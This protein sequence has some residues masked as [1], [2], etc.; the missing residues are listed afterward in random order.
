MSVDGGGGHNR[1]GS[2]GRNGTHK[3]DDSNSYSNGI[4]VIDENKEFTP[5]LPAYL[6]AQNLITTGFSYHVVAVFGSQSTGKST[7]LNHLF[8]T[9]FSVM[10][11]QARRQT[12]K[13][14]WMSRAVEDAKRSDPR[15]MGNNI[16][17]MDVEGTDG[18]ERGEDQDFERKSALFALATSEVLIVNIWEHQVGLYQGANMGLLKT[19]FEVNLGL[20]LKDRSTTHRSLLFF[21]IRDHIGHT[22]LQNLSNTL[23]QDLNR[24]WSSLSKPPGLEDS[25]INDFFDFEFVALP[26][27]IL[28]PERFV[29]ETQKLRKRF[30]EGISPEVEVMSGSNGVD[31]RG[32]GGGVFLPVYHRRIPADGFPRYASGVWTQ[33][34][35]NKDLDLPS[36]Q[37]LLAQY[38]CDEIAATCTAGFNE[39]MSPFE[40][41][42]K[43][44]RVLEGLGGAMKEALGEA[45]GGFEESGG[46]YHKGVF[47]RKREDLRENLE[48]RL[49]GLVVG[50][51]SALSKRAVQEFTEEVTGI[52]RLANASGQSASSNYDFALV[53]NQ[54][55]TKVVDKFIAEASESYIPGAE[56]S[57][58][59]SELTSLQT[60]LD[61]IAAKLRGEQMQRLVARLEKA[62]RS[63]LAEPVELEFRRMEDNS[64]EK[65]NLWDRVWKVWTETVGEGVEGFL[66]RAGNLNATEKERDI[67]AWKLR[68]KAWGVLKAKIEEEVMEGNILLKLRENF[69]D[70]FRYDE[71]GVPR[72]WKPK[73]PIEQTYTTAREATLKL[74]P[75]I[76]R[77]RL[78]SGVEPPLTEFLSD[79]PT[80]FEEDVDEM[81][82][83]KDEFEV[84]G[85]AKQVDLST[86]FKR[87][88][89]AVFVEAKRSTVSSVAE[90]PVFF[91]GV[92]LALGWNELWAVLRSPVYFIFLLLCGAAAYVV[93]TLN[94]WGPILRITN[95][96]GQQ[97]VDIGKERLRDF[98]ADRNV[99][100]PGE[101]NRTKGVYESSDVINL[102]TLDGEGR[103][104]TR[105]KREDD[106][107]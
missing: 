87:M 92:M 15:G 63:K 21:V 61:E 12:T 20:F 42:A 24:I 60:A 11:E 51:F 45:M 102:Q 97:A 74:I 70:R 100:Y 72:V 82:I 67:G 29:E 28:Q 25:K 56:W 62:I 84:L 7:L 64:E 40:E 31:Q 5:Y 52:L 4:Q 85:E 26:H 66:T 44:G 34:V 65:G 90:I 80:D 9:Q 39:I 75:L 32:D 3:K 69:E 1:S 98:V 8:G 46:R 77:I 88:A 2:I 6:T 53:V 48:G 54:T 86:R 76:S 55:R 94:L 96:M 78:S 79:P 95:A 47:E 59:E 71:Q 50:Q 10:D 35:T 103:R 107:E 99:A 83:A 33:I 73:D 89:D 41:R 57:N 14:I 91:W 43:A 81:G 19:V 93:Y 106:D 30:R 101:V 16:L 104:R 22:P 36:Q 58:Y 105:I 49:R 23:M 68:K 27:K 18:R 13:G 37:E 17:V 38:R